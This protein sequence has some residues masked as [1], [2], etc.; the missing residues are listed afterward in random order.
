MVTSFR[1]TSLILFFISSYLL[2]PKLV[3]GAQA[4]T[5]VDIRNSQSLTKI[6]NVVN[7]ASPALKTIESDLNIDSE[8]PYFG[9][10]NSRRGSGTR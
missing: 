8:I 10:P 1:I 6:S 5:Y 3:D 4:F 2:I 9:E 7:A